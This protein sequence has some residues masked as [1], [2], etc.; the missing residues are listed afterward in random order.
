[1]S[2]NKKGYPLLKGAENIYV[3]GLKVLMFDMLEA[4]REWPGVFL[5]LFVT[6]W[7]WFEVRHLSDIMA[8]R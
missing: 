8:V 2:E 3:N 1:M 7:K 5:W 4:L 6:H